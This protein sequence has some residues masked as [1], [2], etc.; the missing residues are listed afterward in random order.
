MAV[1][2]TSERLE[3]YNRFQNLLYDSTLKPVSRYSNKVK[4]GN[5]MEDQIQ[6][7]YQGDVRKFFVFREAG[8]ICGQILANIQPLSYDWNIAGK[9]GHCHDVL[10]KREYQEKVSDLLI[11][12]SSF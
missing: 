10:Q 3:R 1:Q 4:V 6:Q 5:W 8:I 11:L 2:G 7:H 9:V 12:A